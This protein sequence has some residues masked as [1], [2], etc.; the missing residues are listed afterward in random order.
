MLAGIPLRITGVGGGVKGFMC[1]AKRF[2]LGLFD[3]DLVLKN[4]HG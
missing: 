2:Q 3:F 4:I 1:G